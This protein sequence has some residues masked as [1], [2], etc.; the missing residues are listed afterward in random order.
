MY[1]TNQK[2]YWKRAIRNQGGEDKITLNWNLN[3]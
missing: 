3:K 1:N 2:P